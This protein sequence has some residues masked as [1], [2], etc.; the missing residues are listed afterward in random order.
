MDYQR[1]LAMPHN[2]VRVLLFP[3]LTTEVLVS[4]QRLNGGAIK[5]V[6]GML[7]TRCH[8]KVPSAATTTE[9]TYGW[10]QWS[11]APLETGILVA[12]PDGRSL[13]RTQGRSL[14]RTLE[15]DGP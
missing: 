3:K 14:T 2:G 12:G 4:Y 10:S 8:H 11:V 15:R 6:Q 1:T 5:K 7:F 9:G 13:V